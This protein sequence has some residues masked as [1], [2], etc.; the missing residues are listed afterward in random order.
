MN[1][2]E[3][4]ELSRARILAHASAE[5]AQ[6]GYHSASVN[7]ICENGKI[8]KGLM[9]HYFKDKDALYLACIQTCYSKITELVWKKLDL[10]SVTVEDFFDS[11]TAYFEKHPMYYHL[12]LDSITNTCPRIQEQLKQCRSEHDAITYKIFCAIWKNQYQDAAMD[13]DFAITM[14]TIMRRGLNAYIETQ[15]SENFTPADHSKLCKQVVN[16]I[17]RGMIS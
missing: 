2:K 11:R 12:Y 14:L 9:Y 1:Q 10:E 16:T 13:T 5:F 3:R 4:N 15:K 7:R 17:I 8:S 6:H